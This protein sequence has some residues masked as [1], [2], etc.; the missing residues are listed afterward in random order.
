MAAID[1]L[2]AHYDDQAAETALR[3]AVWAWGA[4]GLVILALEAVCVRSGFEMLTHCWRRHRPIA[5]PVTAVAV[6]H[7]ADVL[8]PLDPISHLGK[9]LMHLASPRGTK[10]VR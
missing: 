9:G 6:L 1:I 8:G 10:E 3:S 7:L 2:D 4:L 5:V